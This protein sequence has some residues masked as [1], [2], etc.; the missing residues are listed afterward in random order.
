MQVS[1]QLAE[2]SNKFVAISDGFGE[3][4]GPAPTICACCGSTVKVVKPLIDLNANTIA[5]GDKSVKTTPMCVEVVHALGA[6]YPNAIAHDRLMFAL[7]GSNGEQGSAE[8]L[9][10]H[11]TKTRQAIAPLGLRIENVWGQG[12]RLVIG[13]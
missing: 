1:A 12:Y 8:T 13:Q 4:G 11:I 7:W 3:S 10:V 2:H 6:A 5:W 9:K